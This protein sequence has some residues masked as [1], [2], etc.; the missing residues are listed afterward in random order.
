M[1]SLASQ[2]FLELGQS[3]D[4]FRF[5]KLKEADRYGELP[6]EEMQILSSLFPGS[7][8]TYCFESVDYKRL[9]ESFVEF[10][11]VLRVIVEP[12]LVSPHPVFWWIGIAFSWMTIGPVALAAIN[13]G[14]G[15]KLASLAFFGIWILLGGSCLIAALRV[16]PATLRKLTSFIP[17]DDRPSRALD[18]NDAIPVFLSAS[19]LMGFIFL[20]VPSSTKFAVLLAAL[21]VVN[22]IFRQAL[23]AP[24]RAGRTVLEELEDFR[25]F[26]SRTD[27]DRLNRENEAGRTP[28]VLE[29]YS[30]Y[31]VALDAEH[32]WGEELVQDVV[33][34]LQW[35]Q[36]YT[37]RQNWVPNPPEIIE[38]K[39]NDR[40]R[41]RRR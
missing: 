34:L 12:D 24:T 2:G 25:E 21:V 4:K 11:D 40:K 14:D 8:D 32:Y 29:K 39:I 6:Q 1:V 17:W 38:L 33:E 3:D 9:C 5:E 30:A 27:T 28:K 36:A 35:D 20:A 31:A 16:W 18:V 41:A 37:R 22:A 26:L 7:A 15:I 13:I 23:H 19:S 10:K